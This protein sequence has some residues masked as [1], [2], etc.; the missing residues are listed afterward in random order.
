MVNTLIKLG[1]TTCVH[2]KPTVYP[3]RGRER[4]RGNMCVYSN[5]VGMHVNSF[6]EGMTLSPGHIE[7]MHQLYAL[8]CI[9]TINSIIEGWTL[10]HTDYSVYGVY[11]E[12][13]SITEGL[14]G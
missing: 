5:N 7:Y 4:E 8:W 13:N 2:D 10:T 14:T 3:V 9:L 11:S 6:P 1:D 12:F